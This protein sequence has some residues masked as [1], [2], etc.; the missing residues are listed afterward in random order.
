MEEAVLEQLKYPI[1]KYKIPNPITEAHLSDWISVLEKLP[2]RFEKMVSPLT[3]EQ[4]ET[5]YRS[6]GW[7]VRQPD[8]FHQI[9]CISTCGN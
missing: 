5:P 8:R 1:G 2:E 4:L 9:T 7:T 3:E 6:E